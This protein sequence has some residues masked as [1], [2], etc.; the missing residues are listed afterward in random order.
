VAEQTAIDHF[1][2][3]VA[4]LA[5]ATSPYSLLLGRHPSWQGSHPDQGKENTLFKLDNIYV[6][7]LATSGKGMAADLVNQLLKERGQCL[8]GLVFATR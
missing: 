6:E 5:H 3:A 4:D 1:I 8:G 7:L 2:I